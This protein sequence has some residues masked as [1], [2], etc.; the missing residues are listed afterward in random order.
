VVCSDVAEGD[1]GAYEGGKL[2]QKVRVVGNSVDTEALATF[3]QKE[4]FDH[5]GQGEVG[6]FGGLLS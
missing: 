2:V 6:H 3:G 1:V 4:A 5:L